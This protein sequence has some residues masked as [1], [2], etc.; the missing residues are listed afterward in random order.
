[1]TFWAHVSGEK[2]LTYGHED[3]AI[4]V[5]PQSVE[6]LGVPAEGSRSHSPV[7]MGILEQQMSPLGIH[8]YLLSIRVEVQEN[9]QRVEHSLDRYTGLG[10]SVTKSMIGRLVGWHIHNETL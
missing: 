8:E 10:P 2:A 9:H 6:D 7:R 1:M 4:P 5:E 3:N